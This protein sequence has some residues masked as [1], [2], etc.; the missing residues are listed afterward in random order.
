MLLENPI[1]EEATV[2]RTSLAPGMLD[3]LAWN[4]NRGVA[5][6][7]LFESGTVFAAAGEKV[8]ERKALVI[9]AT[10]NAV[11]ASVHEES[12]AYTFYDLKGDVETLLNE[13]EQL[14]KARDKVINDLMSELKEKKTLLAKQEIEVWKSIERRAAWKHRLSKIG[15]RIKTS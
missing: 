14:L 15:I 1:S 2:M 6:A 12:R 3:M 11:S 5:G 13:R 8:E 10:G 4:L 9:G 7:R